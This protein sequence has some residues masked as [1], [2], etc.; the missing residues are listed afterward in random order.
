MLK[1]THLSIFLFILAFA[2]C[3]QAN[4]RATIRK[5]LDKVGRKDAAVE[6]VAEFSGAGRAIKLNLNKR[7]LAGVIIKEFPMEILELT[8]LKGLLLKD[9]DL[10]TLPA[11]IGR[12]TDL[13]ELDL[14][15]NSELGSLPSS[16]GNLSNLRKLD[17][18]LCGL[19]GLPPEFGNLKN[20]EVLQL[21]N[22][23]FVMLPDCILELSNL[24]DLHLNNNKLITLPQGITKMPN[25]AY[26]DTQKN[27]LC[28]LDP[29]VDKWLSEKEKRYKEHQ[30]CK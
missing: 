28:D 19:T 22:N 25:L 27:S 12:M 5:I 13:V 15:N 2:L 23:G 4:D 9:N 16:I 8:A 24:R 21:W 1:K 26:I 20:L 29:A 17:I 11:E 3:A 10:K 14:A 30:W 6:D 18:R 7:G